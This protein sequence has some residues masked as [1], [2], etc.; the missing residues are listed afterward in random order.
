MDPDDYQHFVTGKVLTEE[1][2]NPEMNVSDDMMEKYG[3]VKEI[4][5][6]GITRERQAEIIGQ[7]RRSADQLEINTRLQRHKKFHLGKLLNQENLQSFKV[8]FEKGLQYK[9]LEQYLHNVREVASAN[10]DKAAIILQKQEVDKIIKDNQSKVKAKNDSISLMREQMEINNA[11][12]AKE[13]KGKYHFKKFKGGSSGVSS[14]GRS[15][16][17]SLKAGK[18]KRPVIESQ[19]ITIENRTPTQ[20]SNEVKKKKRISNFDASALQKLDTV[21]KMDGN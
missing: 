4:K 13:L 11:K 9:Y 18:V 16:T 3:L 12:F 17:K 2:E 8:E 7:L 19:E 10:V 21:L 1:E 15:G 14:G 20:K 6:V 5:A